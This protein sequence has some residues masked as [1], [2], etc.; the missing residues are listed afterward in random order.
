MILKTLLFTLF[1]TSCTLSPAY[2]YCINV[3]IYH[4]DGTQQVCQV[5]YDEKGNEV[6]RVCR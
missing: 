1:L 4:G 5:C 6:S 3:T 2:A